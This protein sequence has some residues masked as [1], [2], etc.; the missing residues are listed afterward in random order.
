MPE[1]I[2]PAVIYDS[3]RCILCIKAKGRCIVGSGRSAVRYVYLVG[4]CDV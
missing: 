3:H 1:I 4:V 2:S